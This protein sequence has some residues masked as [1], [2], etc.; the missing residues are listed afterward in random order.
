MRPRVLLM[1]AAALALAAAAAA[2]P[3]LDQVVGYQIGTGG[4]AG[5]NA[6]PGVVLGAP[7][8]GGAFKGSTD[9]LSLG[10]GGSIVVAFTDNWVVDG[11]GVDLT[12]FENP[13]LPAGVTTGDPW[14]E[15]GAV[16]VSADA[17]HWA[18]FPC[19]MDAPPFYP[20]C[21]GVYPVFANRDD[22]AAPS[23]LVPCTEPVSSLVGVPVATFVPPRC[24]GGD[25]F[26]LAQVG[27][28]AI[29]FVRIQG[30]P[31]QPAL[32]GLA[33]FDLDAIAG[34][35]SVDVPPGAPDADGDGVPDVVDDCPHTPDPAQQDT[36]GDGVG[37]ACDDCPTLYDPEQQHA[38]GGSPT[39][40]PPTMPPPTL[41]PAS[42][43]GS[44]AP[45]DPDQTHGAANGLLAYLAP[46][47]V[48]TVMPPGTAVAT[49]IVVIAPDVQAGSVRVRVG[50]RDWTARLG[51]FVPGTT[52]TLTIPLLRRR[53]TVRLRAQ[54]VRTT[55][56]RLVDVDRFVF[57]RRKQ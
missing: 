2:D 34:V 18:S 37:D 12:V 41:P 43:G 21:A 45:F 16:S 46:R 4:G 3:Y 20:G 23:P 14:A 32:G 35:H 15:P 33:G 38:C 25:S 27:L 39:P 31:I 22:P 53:T 19:R 42:G 6:L 51:P 26:D 50:A 30:G 29:R 54:A 40:P 7:V 44:E 8:G 52:K 57:E 55:G 11:P 47:A 5:V 13:F 36:D 24:S 49:V 1:L 48:R 28:H 56:R 17:V 10:L 9:T